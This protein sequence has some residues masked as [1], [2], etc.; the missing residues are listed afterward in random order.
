LNIQEQ[1]KIVN[2]KIKAEFT[3]NNASIYGEY[4]LFSDYLVANGLKNL[5]E[6]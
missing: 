1:E 6:K 4:N 5:I 3:L 2:K